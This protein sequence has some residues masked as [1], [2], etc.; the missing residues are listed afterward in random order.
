[1]LGAI[2]PLSNTGHNYP[3]SRGYMLSV[4]LHTMSMVLYVVSLYVRIC[5]YESIGHRRIP[6]VK[7]SVRRA[8][9]PPWC[10][11]NSRLGAHGR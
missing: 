8:G 11:D 9:G 2:A 6:H 5:L 7:H 1:M 10:G 4:V 3:Y